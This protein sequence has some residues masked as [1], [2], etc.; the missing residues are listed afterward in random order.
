MT[1]VEERITNNINNGVLFEFLGAENVERL[2]TE[3][4]V[5]KIIFMSRRKE[6]FLT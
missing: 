4:T 2:K 5:L 6:R 1:K 3:I